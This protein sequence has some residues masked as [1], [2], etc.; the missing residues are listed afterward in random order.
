MWLDSPS[1]Y[2]PSMPLF[3]FGR[4][5]EP[6]PRTEPET[7]LPEPDDPREV[8][9][10]LRDM[11]LGLD[12]RQIGVEPTRELPRV[13]GI[14]V[15]W[16]TDSGTATFVALADRT[17]SMYT[18]GGGGVIG[19]GEHEPVRVAAQR[20]LEV[21]EW[22]VDELPPVRAAGPPDVARVTYWVLTYDGIRTTSHASGPPDGP[23]WLVDLGDAFQ[24]FV[25][26]I[27]RSSESAG[28]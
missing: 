15:D 19:A 25:S 28:R 13:W 3:G 27:R 16:G 11:V 8:Y 10:G 14:V 7:P 2:A 18:S 22:S 5:K 23:H 17:A 1:P 4:R 20:L 9:A 24:D 12:P 21:A 6:E 26:A